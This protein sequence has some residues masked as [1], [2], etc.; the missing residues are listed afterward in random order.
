MESSP[1]PG[2]HSSEDHLQRV[3]S[4][5]CLII[6][7]S[8]FDLSFSIHHHEAAEPKEQNEPEYVFAFAGGDAD[9]L[10]EKGAALLQALEHVALKAIGLEE[11]RTIAFDCR[12]W[13][14]MR[15]EELRMMAQVA[16]DRVIETGAPF[17][18]S[19]MSSRER[20]IVH[21]ALK[22]RPQVRTRSEGVGSE[23][24]VTIFPAN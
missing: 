20:R 18:L 3:E 12:G 6:E 9:L 16:A 8:P 4:L 17:T 2:E 13:R 5:L 19:P 15:M 21:L 22:D 10:L 23:R 1:S 7:H 14:R 11:D 24:K